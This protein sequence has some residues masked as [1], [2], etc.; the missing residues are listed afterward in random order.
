MFYVQQ[1]TTG[2]D[3]TAPIVITK[4]EEIENSGEYA[5]V[6]IR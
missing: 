1:S 4:K 6:K 5:I 3:F 2:A